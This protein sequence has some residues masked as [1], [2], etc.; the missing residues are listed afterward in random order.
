MKG[1]EP[2]SSKAGIRRVAFSCC[3]TSPRQYLCMCV[4]VCV[5]GN[6]GSV[7][8][9]GTHVFLISASG[10]C[11]CLR[12]SVSGL[13]VCTQECASYLH[14]CVEMCS[15]GFVCGWTS[16]RTVFTGDSAAPVGTALLD[17]DTAAL[18]T[19][20][21]RSSHTGLQSVW[22]AAALHFPEINHAFQNTLAPVVMMQDGSHKLSNQW[23]TCQS[24]LIHIYSSWL[25][26]KKPVGTRTGPELKASNQSFFLFF[27]SLGR[28]KWTEQMW[29]H[30]KQKHAENIQCT[31]TCTLSHYTI[32]WSDD[33]HHTSLVLIT[34]CYA[35][36]GN[37]HDSWLLQF[38]TWS[39]ILIKVL[40][41]T[42]Q[43][44]R[45]TFLMSLWL[46]VEYVA[47][48]VVMS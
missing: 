13:H 41:T 47:F 34:M 28:T 16:I 37:K 11:V 10:V 5:F 39:S 8:T 6:S 32:I 1:S 36:F 22:I 2:S 42:S 24:E 31:Y 12:V 44:E 35:H 18:T 29:K 23:V 17:T 20:E 25:V 4:H 27:F 45:M 14:A 40:A 15:L 9:K 21:S 38:N 7:C 43:A 3:L 46:W 30:R 33:H 26:C 19:P 48:F